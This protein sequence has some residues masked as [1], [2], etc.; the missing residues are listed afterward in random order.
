MLR[1]RKYRRSYGGD[2]RADL[3]NRHAGERPRVA[4]RAE[5]ESAKTFS[6][7]DEIRVLIRVPAQ[8]ADN[9]V[10]GERQHRPQRFPLRSLNRIG[11]RK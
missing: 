1:R 3:I 11:A 7:D 9:D 6:G 10:A 4:I 2:E 5:R 8:S